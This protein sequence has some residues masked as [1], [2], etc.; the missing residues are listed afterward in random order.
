MFHVLGSQR[1]ESG[2]FH[3]RWGGG[4]TWRRYILP[5]IQPVLVGNVVKLLT[6]FFMKTPGSWGT[7]LQNF[8]KKIF[9][10]VKFY[11]Q[12]QKKN[13]Q[14]DY[15][16]FFFAKNMGKIS[17]TMITNRNLHVARISRLRRVFKCNI[18]R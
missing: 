13:M 16:F 3:L 18:C 17:H 7:F 11:Q 4:L 12:Q 10:K 9:L 2:G 1:L 14:Y 15:G 6:L 8:R 5:F